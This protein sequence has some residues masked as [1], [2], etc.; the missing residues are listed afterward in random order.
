MV[1]NLEIIREVSQARTRWLT[2]I[3]ELRQDVGLK[4]GALISLGL[5]LL[6]GISAQVRLPMPFSP[7]PITGQ[8]FVVLL[9]GFIFGK[10][11]G[12]GSQLFYV[13]LG[14][15]GVPWFT[16]LS[17]GLAALA[18]PTGGYILGFL[19]AAYLIGWLSERLELKGISRLFL[20]GLAGLGVIY[21]F[22]SL[23][24][25]LFLNSGFARTISMG[26]LPFAWI[27]LFKV[28]L[29]SLIV[30]EFNPANF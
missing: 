5:A 18:G 6:T 9:L 8:V 29:V 16:G 27:D 15:A 3:S 17:G 11:I 2:I 13:G 25:S 22:G 19:P 23:Q 10:K 24:L 7:V 4:K 26:V 30:K 28:F 14:G 21:F 1:V 12:L 20:A